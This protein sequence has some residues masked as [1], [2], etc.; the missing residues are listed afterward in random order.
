MASQSA[1]TPPARDE[2]K[3]PKEDDP[4][5]QRSAAEAL[6]RRRMQRGFRSTI[7]ASRMFETASGSGGKNTFGS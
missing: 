7:L 1:P 3:A 4:D 5:V 2:A 6:R